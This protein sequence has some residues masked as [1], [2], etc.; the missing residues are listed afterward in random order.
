M[1]TKEALAKQIKCYKASRQHML[2]KI[3]KLNEEK[4]KLTPDKK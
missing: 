4:K 3:A 1:K 2:A